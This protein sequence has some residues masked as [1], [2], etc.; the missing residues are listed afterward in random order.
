MHCEEENYDRIEQLIDEFC[1]IILTKKDSLDE[2]DIQKAKQ[3]IDS[4]SPEDTSNLNVREAKT[5]PKIRSFVLK[6]IARYIKSYYQDSEFEAHQFKRPFEF[7]ALGSYAS[8]C[9]QCKEYYQTKNLRHP[10]PTVLDFTID[11]IQEISEHYRVFVHFYDIRSA[12]TSGST[13]RKMEKSAESKAA[14]AV[15]K[16]TEK[17]VDSKVEDAVKS[18]MHRVTSRMSET[19]V[20]ILG[21]FSGI[22]LSIVTGLFYFSSVIES[23]NSANFYRLFSISALVG[24]VCLVFMTTMFRFIAKIG[25]KEDMKFF[26]DNTVMFVCIV[27][28]LVMVAGFILQFVCPDSDTNISQ[29]NVDSNVTIDVNVSLAEPISETPVD[30]DCGVPQ[31]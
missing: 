12:Q 26:S 20:T 30:E 19:S 28:I 15:Q 11:Y 3:Y 4:L 7:D 22:V 23:I 8:F 18:Q 6:K 10:F 17:V 13:L 27:L 24:L 9:E 1:S 16:I 5:N 29:T 31:I 25:G 2:T 21:I 14:D